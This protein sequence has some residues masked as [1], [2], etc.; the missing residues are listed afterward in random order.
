[1]NKLISMK[2]PIVLMSAFAMGP[3]IAAA[4]D[5]KCDCPCADNRAS[6]SAETDQD[7]Y[8]ASN[9]NKDQDRYGASNTD[10]DQDRYGAATAD[11][12]QDRYGTSNAEKD[13]DKYGAGNSD[14]DQDLHTTTGSE[15]ASDRA[16]PAAKD[17][18]ASGAAVH[19]Q[20]Y[21]TAKPAE[22]YFS[23]SLIGLTVNNRRDNADIGTVDELLIGQDG[24]IAAVIVSI[25]GVMGIGEKDVAIAWDQIERE[26][27]GD[28]ITLSVDLSES[29]LS[30]AP[31]FDRE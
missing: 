16:N 5:T 14:K 25:G 3:T 7:R 24:K 4:D 6:V 31:S 22:D 28:E 1:M 8:G 26:V 29:S 20:D 15:M 2:Y 21:L 23:E 10:K 27:D 19:G 17:R 9:T 13:K 30:E 11:N 18:A 12:D